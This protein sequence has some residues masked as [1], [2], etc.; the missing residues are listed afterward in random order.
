MMMAQ[1]LHTMQTGMANRYGIPQVL[2]DDRWYVYQVD[3]DIMSTTQR[4]R[5]DVISLCYKKLDPRFARSPQVN[6]AA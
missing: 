1:T 4:A 3:L 5:A 6:S 2:R